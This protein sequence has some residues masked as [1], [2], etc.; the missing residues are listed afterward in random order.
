MTGLSGDDTALV[1]PAASVAVAVRACVPID[2]GEV[3]TVQL[4]VALVVVVPTN[5]VPSYTL[6]VL[7]ASAVP[8]NCTWFPLTIESLAST[9]AFGATVSTVTVNT[10]DAA[11]V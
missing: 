4:P 2:S 9:G 7:F 1:F 3:V 10:D 11:L 6:S 8:V 5:V